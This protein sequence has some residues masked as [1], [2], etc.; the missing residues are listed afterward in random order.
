MYI[1]RL[2][3]TM[4]SKSRFINKHFDAVLQLLNMAG[5]EV[6]QQRGN[7]N[8]T[9]KVM[10]ATTQSL[11]GMRKD[12]FLLLLGSVGQRMSSSVRK[13]VLVEKVLELKNAVR[14]GTLSLKKRSSSLTN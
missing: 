6:F 1:L 9:K 8:G 7:P 2:F 4:R 12:D 3:Q 13:Q 14:D 11:S 10:S 5:G